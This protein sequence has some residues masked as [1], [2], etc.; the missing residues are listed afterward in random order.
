MA[1]LS[2]S[3]GWKGPKAQTGAAAS[4]SPCGTKALKSDSS[5]VARLAT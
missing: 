5:A 4:F 2:P 1:P 3:S